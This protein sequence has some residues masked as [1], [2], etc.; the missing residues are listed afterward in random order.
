MYLTYD[1]HTTPIALLIFFGRLC[2]L[3]WGLSTQS[4]FHAGAL[5]RARRALVGQEEPQ[6]DL[7]LVWCFGVSLGVAR[8]ES[9]SRLYW[10]DT[11]SAWTSG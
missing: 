7:G 10:D 2:I 3:N 8:V 1:N 5:F 11:V 6:K 4:D 9:L